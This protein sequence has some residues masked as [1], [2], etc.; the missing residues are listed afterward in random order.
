[1]ESVFLIVLLRHGQ[2]LS[3]PTEFAQPHVRIQR[4]EQKVMV[5]ISQGSAFQHVQ[6]PIS[7][8]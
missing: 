8:K 4:V 3:M 6:I 7:D 2:I 5:T 1:M